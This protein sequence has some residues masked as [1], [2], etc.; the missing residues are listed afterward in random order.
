MC[1]GPEG[2]RSLPQSVLFFKIF[3]FFESQEMER[4]IF[5]ILV[6]SSG[7][8]SKGWARAR[9]SVLVSFAAFIGALPRSAARR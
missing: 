2:D 4:Q 3:F 1:R 5:C 7:H 9:S 8:N 6:H